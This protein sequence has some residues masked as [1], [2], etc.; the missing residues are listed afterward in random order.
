MRDFFYSSPLVSTFSFPGQEFALH[1]KETV[2][3]KGD[4][5]KSHTDEFR[6][7]QRKMENDGKDE[8]VRVIR[9]YMNL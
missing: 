3:G 9:H 1:C 2:E 5:M 7:W 8:A 4:W 6:N